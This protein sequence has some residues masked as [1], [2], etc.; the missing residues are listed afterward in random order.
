[1]AKRVL[2]GLLKRWGPVFQHQVINILAYGSGAFPQT[3]DKQVFASNTLD[4]IVEVR[5]PDIFHRE[6]MRTSPNDYSGAVSIA[7]SSLLNWTGN[8]LFPMHSNHIN[9]EGKP[10]KYSVIGHLPLRED[11]RTWKYLSFAGR[12]QKPVFPLRPLAERL[13]EDM[14]RNR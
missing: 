1:M 13:G 5:N 4:L 8:S 14:N 11:L 7:G 9:L 12:L 3:K 10:I 6:V 2:T